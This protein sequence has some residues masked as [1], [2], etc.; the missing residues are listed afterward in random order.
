MD[1]YAGGTKLSN[2]HFALDLCT[3]LPRATHFAVLAGGATS[4]NKNKS[5]GYVVVHVD[6]AAPG[7]ATVNPLTGAAQLASLTVTRSSDVTSASRKCDICSRMQSRAV[8]PRASSQ[9]SGLSRA[10]ES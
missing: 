6:V 4:H 7:G 2:A 1:Q 10:W 8:V 9:L 3:P 5:F